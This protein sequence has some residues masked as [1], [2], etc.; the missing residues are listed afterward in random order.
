MSD[1]KF[2]NFYLGPE[3]CY[4]YLDLIPVITF[5]FLEEKLDFI[6]IIPFDL[7]LIIPANNFLNN[8]LVNLPVLPNSKESGEPNPSNQKYSLATLSII[9]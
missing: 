4:I 5:N 3:T 6:L 7:D 2:G 1:E 8:F 9:Y